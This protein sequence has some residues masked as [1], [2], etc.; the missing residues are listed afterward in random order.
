MD[1]WKYILVPSGIS[2]SGN[3]ACVQVVVSRNSVS[4]MFMIYT[5]F[6]GRVEQRAGY[7]V[8]T[9]FDRPTWR[10]YSDWIQANCED[11]EWVYENLI[12]QSLDK[13]KG[14]RMSE[15]DTLMFKIR[16]GI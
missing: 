2:R 9:V 7:Q 15:E 14:V 10:E 6:G 1:Q 11:V 5:A 16:F 12:T 13:L 3:N 4:V 8:V